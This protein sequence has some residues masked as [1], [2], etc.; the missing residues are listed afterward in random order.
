[1]L[2]EAKDD[3]RRRRWVWQAVSDL[4]LDEEPDDADLRA[5][6]RT[7]AECEYSTEELEAIYRQEVAPA[8]AFNALSTAG[9][10]GYFD[11]EWL[12]GRILRCNALGYWITRLTIAPLVTQLLSNKWKRI[13]SFMTEECQRVERARLENGWKPC[14]A[15]EAPIYRWGTAGSGETSAE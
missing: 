12:E 11:T 8:L 6:A 9:V 3:L 1:M 5:I 7:A 13:K 14:C 2:P 15:G 10:W 4:F